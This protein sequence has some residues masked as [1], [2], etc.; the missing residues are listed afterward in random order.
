MKIA[1]IGYGKMGRQVES[2]AAGR[3][4]DVILRVDPKAVNADSSQ[5]HEDIRN[6]DVCIEFTHPNSVVD[7]IRTIV[8]FKTPL[9]TGTT[10]WFDRI[11]E[12]RKWVEDSG[13]GFVFAPN[14]SLGMNLFFKIV[15]QAADIMNRFKS[16]DISGTEIHHNAKADAPS[17]TAKVISKILIDR[18]DRKREAV[19]NLGNRKIEPY[20]LHFTS[21]RIGSVPGIHKIIFDS[22][23]DTLE[24]SHSARNREGFALGAVTAAEWIAG[25]KGFYSFSEIIEQILS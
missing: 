20:E 8:D 17:G 9:V 18:I 3:G 4:H 14:F 25:K 1:L 5:C 19:Y 12:V 2:V 7:N 10:G 22:T 16:Y 23:A 21:Q 13:T 24:L 11:D 15:E 6:A